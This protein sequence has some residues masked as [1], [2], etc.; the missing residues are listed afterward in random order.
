MNVLK[1]AFAIA[2]L[3]VSACQVA[4]PTGLPQDHG[5]QQADGHCDPDAMPC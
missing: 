3:A 4:S 2:V 5:L 1:L